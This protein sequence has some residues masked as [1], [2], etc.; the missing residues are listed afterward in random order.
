MP[1]LNRDYPGFGDHRLIL[2]LPLRGCFP[3]FLL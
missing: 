3:V 1:L 2:R